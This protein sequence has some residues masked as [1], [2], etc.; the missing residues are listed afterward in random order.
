MMDDLISRAAAIECIGDMIKEY[1]EKGEDGIADGMILARRYGIKRLP[2]IASMAALKASVPRLLTPDELK[3]WN[4]DVWV[5]YIGDDR[6]V[7]VDE[8]LAASM[9]EF[10]MSMMRDKVRFWT[11]RPTEEQRK[12]VALE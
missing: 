2:T 12:A 3:A 6:I 1:R 8:H 5:E 9:T 11:A 4:K 7:V 10:A